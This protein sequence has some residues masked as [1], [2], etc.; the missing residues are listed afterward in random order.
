MSE[1]I[2]LKGRPAFHGKASGKALVCKNSIQGWGGMNGEEGT[3]LEKGHIHEGVSIKDRILVLPCSKGSCGWS[4]QFHAC[5]ESGNSPA[6]WLFSKIDS[7][8]ATAASVLKIPVVSDFTE[9]DP[10]DMINSGDWV[11]MDGDTGTV[12]VTKS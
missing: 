7:R 9:C 1:K 5:M 2:T 6:G 4:G 8:C 10:C 12:I 11:E 3:I